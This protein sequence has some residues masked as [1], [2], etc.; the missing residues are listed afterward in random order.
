MRIAVAGGSGLLG[1]QVVR[2]LLAAEH[3]PVVLARSTGVDITT[4]VGLDAALEGVHALIDVSNVGAISKAKSVRFFTSGSGHLLDAGS[5]AGVRHHVA[6][7]IV[8]VDRVQFGYY[9]GKLAQ[10]RLLLGSDAP[11]SVLRA[12]QFHEFA[13]QLL[14]RSRGPVV[15]PKMKSQPVAA[16]EVAQALAELVAG[17][18][19]GMAPELAGPQIEDMFDMVRR[20]NRLRR[21]HRRLLSVRLPGTVG[22]AMASGGLLPLQDGPRGRQ[23]FEQWLVA[24]GSELRLT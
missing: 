10:E 8:G 16:R 21:K 1:R 7:S 20:V 19:V 12:T 24:A 15:V 4:G 13:G 18:A 6:L 23:T 22:R 2:T 17:P 3:D 14:D 11:V 9:Q 5:R